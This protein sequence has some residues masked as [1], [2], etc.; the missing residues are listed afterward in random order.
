MVL[1]TM[2]ECAKECGET[3][4]VT[5][6]HFSC[7]PDDGSEKNHGLIMGTPEN[8][9]ITVLKGMAKN[10]M[11]RDIIMTAAA[12]YSMFNKI[13]GDEIRKAE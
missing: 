12:S 5:M 2:H 1:D 3:E 9:V 7:F 6:I 8:L 11:I 13:V 4:G 10:P